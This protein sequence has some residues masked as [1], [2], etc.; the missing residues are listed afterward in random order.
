[1]KELGSS[2]GIGLKCIKSEDDVFS[3][4]VMEFSDSGITPIIEERLE[5][6]RQLDKSE[7][8][9]LVNELNDSQLS[10][11]HG[12]DGKQAND[13]GILFSL[14]LIWFSFLGT[15]TCCIL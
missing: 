4:A 15:R 3:D 1:M 9:E 10:E 5:K 7:G 6:V 14:L 13:T 12:T 2:D 8:E 11:D